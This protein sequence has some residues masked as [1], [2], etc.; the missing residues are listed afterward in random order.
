MLDH[1]ITEPKLNDSQ[2]SA[3]LR[4]QITEPRVWE[5]QQAVQ[6]VFFPE[7]INLHYSMVNDNHEYMESAIAIE[8]LQGVLTGRGKLIKTP[9]PAS[10]GSKEKCDYD[11]YEV[12]VQTLEIVG[13]IVPH[14]TTLLPYAEW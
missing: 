14:D 10:Q 2:C 5:L 13:V 12:H 4:H 9:P 1:Q 11:Y 8:A 3:L 7:E 6:A